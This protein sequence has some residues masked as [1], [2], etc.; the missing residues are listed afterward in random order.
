MIPLNM[1]L[2]EEFKDVIEVEQQYITLYFTLVHVPKVNKYFIVAKPAVGE[3]TSFEMRTEDGEVWKLLSPA[4]T[5]ATSR[6]K[7]LSQLISDNNS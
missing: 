6:E 5:W 1:D 7:E 2:R 4:P 3:V